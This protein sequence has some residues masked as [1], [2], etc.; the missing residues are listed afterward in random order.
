[1]NAEPQN[2]VIGIVE[3]VP[4]DA[5][6]WGGLGVIPYAGTSLATV[7]LARQASMAVSLGESSGLNADTAL[8]LLSQVQ[9]IQ[10]AYGAVLLSFL[11]A[12]HWGFEVSIFACDSR[13]CP[14]R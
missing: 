12:I 10:V 2:S 4:K 13:R 3:A 6:V 11:G 9:Q 14:P 7:Y 8:L 1:M 5:L